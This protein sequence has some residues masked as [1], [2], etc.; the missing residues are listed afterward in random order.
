[1]RLKTYQNCQLCQGGVV[2]SIGKIIALG[3]STHGPAYRRPGRADTRRD[4]DGPL[5]EPRA[6]PAGNYPWIAD[7][8]NENRHADGED[9][10]LRCDCTESEIKKG[11]QPLFCYLGYRVDIAEFL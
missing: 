7:G 11:A 10:R 5:L 2:T 8:K 6:A 4:R 3:G 9:D 1:M